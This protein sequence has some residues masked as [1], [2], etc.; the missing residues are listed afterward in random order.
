[1]KLVATFKHFI[2]GGGQRCGTTYLAQA[3]SAH[4]EIQMASPD[5]PEPKFFLRSDLMKDSLIGYY[6]EFFK[7]RENVKYL[8]EKSTSY[9]ESA[10]AA[11]RIKS[12]LPNAKLIFQLREPVARAR[13]N[14]SF[15]RAHGFETD[16]EDIAIMRELD[17][18]KHAVSAE[19]AAISVSPHAYLARGRYAHYLRP[20]LESFER[21]NIYVALMENTIGSLE[22]VQ[23][24]YRFLDVDDKF[25]PDMLSQQINA[26][27]HKMD[28]ALP[29]SIHTRLDDFFASHNI[30]LEA[31][32]GLDLSPWK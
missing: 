18:P 3:L 23:D 4:P 2:I 28:K 15:S 7:T 20:Y 16:P 11:M 12:L 8:G 31:L 17:K 26:S 22:A 13:S 10:D 21:E 27:D 32:T 24:I 5:R 9:I 29:P 14:I 1:M 19:E 6:N 25:V 30:E